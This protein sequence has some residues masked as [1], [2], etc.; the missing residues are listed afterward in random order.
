MIRFICSCAVVLA[1]AS[2]CCG[3]QAQ[4]YKGNL[5]THSLWSDGND[6]PDMITRWYAERDYHF[7][8]MTDHNVLSVGDRWMP[9]E[10]VNKRG[11]KDTFE[12]YQVAF[13]KE[14]VETRETEQGK[15]EVRLKT[16]EEYRSRFE[17]PGKFLLMTGEEISDSVDGKPV[18]MNATNLAELIRPASG[19]SI[20]EAINNNLR[21]AKEQAE[22]L[23]R[24]I[25]VHLNHPNFGW[26]ITGEDLAY[27]TEEK[28]FE[29]FNGHPGV[30]QLGDEVHPSVERLWDIANAIRISRL[31]SAPLFGIATDDCHEYHGRP[32]SQPGRAWIMVR[33]DQLKPEPLL[34]AVNRGEFYASSGVELESVNFDDNRLSIRIKPQEGVTF[35][36]AF[37]GTPKDYDQTTKVQRDKEGKELPNVTRI[38]SPDVGKVFAEAK[39]DVVEYRLTGDE[40]YV[41][42]VITSS[43]PHPNPSIKD[44]KQQ[45]WTQPV[46]WQAH[47]QNS[48]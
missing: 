26:A 7:L 40:L 29:I 48:R 22:K 14:W 21:S 18:H 31:N 46:G 24:T 33:S 16:L 12:K 1:M 23:D 36:T 41:R 25:L 28:F 30:N 17:Q 11:A 32:G 38:Y 6:F 37:V 3:F 2:T 39:G 20:V 34:K 27:V 19:Q 15:T 9:L 13:G 42:A 47:L 4:W 5:H 8:A 43:Q 45:A 44:Q 35:T 10:T